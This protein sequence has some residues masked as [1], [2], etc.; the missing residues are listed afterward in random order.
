[1]DG[2]KMPITNAER[3][4]DVV[5]GEVLMSLKSVVSTATKERRSQATTTEWFMETR[6]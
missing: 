2:E 3:L 5:A 1:M 6:R 4:L